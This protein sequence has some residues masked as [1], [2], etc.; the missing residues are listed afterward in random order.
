MLPKKQ[1]PWYELIKRW[2]IL[3]LHRTGSDRKLLV[4][5]L[6]NHNSISPDKMIDGS[7]T[8]CGIHIIRLVW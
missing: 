6:T 7:L 2:V 1:T 5:A 4:I 3:G 8:F